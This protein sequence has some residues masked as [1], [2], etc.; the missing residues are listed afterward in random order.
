MSTLTPDQKSDIALIASVCVP[1]L[2]A[3]IQAVANRFKPSSAVE[4][5]RNNVVTRDKAGAFNRPETH[6]VVAPTF[7][8]PI[9]KGGYE[10]PGLGPIRLDEKQYVH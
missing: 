8:R 9:K 5:F 6:Y 4:R 10:V 1:V 2:I 3:V 7:I